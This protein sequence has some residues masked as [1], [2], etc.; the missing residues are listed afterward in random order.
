MHGPRHRQSG[1][2]KER[3]PDLIRPKDPGW[4]EGA[5]WPTAGGVAVVA[6]P[7]SRVRLPQPM[8]L[9]VVATMIKWTENLILN[10]SLGCKG[11]FRHSPAVPHVTAGRWATLQPFRLL[12]CASFFPCFLCET[13]DQSGLRGGSL[14]WAV[15]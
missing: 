4:P 6:S 14:A 1:E 9:I 8:R 2:G 10:T 15:R 13:A 11:G 12:P 7:P 3:T 5:P